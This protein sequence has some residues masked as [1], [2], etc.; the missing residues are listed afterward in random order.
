[1]SVCA[2]LVCYVSN[3]NKR[4]EVRWR[5]VSMGFPGRESRGAKKFNETSRIGY[6]EFIMY[7]AHTHYGYNISL[8]LLHVYI[9][10]NIT[11]ILHSQCFEIGRMWCKNADIKSYSFLAFVSSVILELAWWGDEWHYIVTISNFLSFYLLLSKWHLLNQ[12][13]LVS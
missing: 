13:I 1:M 9:V 12:C 6:Y 7:L 10:H 11:S 4:G 3:E 5:D 8:F 2:L